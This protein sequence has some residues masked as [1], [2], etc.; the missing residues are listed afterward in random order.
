[1]AMPAGLVDSHSSGTRTD[2]PDVS[3]HDVWDVVKYSHRRLRWWD[4]SSWVGAQEQSMGT[5]GEVD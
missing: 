4:M 1:V 5:V 2:A 3:L